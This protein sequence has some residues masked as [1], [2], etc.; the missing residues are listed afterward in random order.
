MEDFEKK[1]LEN[2]E[3]RILNDTKR[4]AVS[5]QRFYFIDPKNADVVDTERVG[6]LN[7]KVYTLEIPESRLRTLMELEKKF[8]NYLNNGGERNMFE[9]V[10]N[11]LREE[12]SL[13]HQYPVVQKAYEH[14][15]VAL[16][17]VGYERKI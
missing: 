4:R 9:L 10:M 2:Y 5:T 7:E 14:Y 13:R 12:A 3:I 1:F 16:H 11:K 15:S 6:Y 17:L 8:Y